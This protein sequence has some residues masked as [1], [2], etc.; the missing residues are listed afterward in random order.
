[1]L[2]TSSV[3]SFGRRRPL[4]VV[5]LDAGMRVVATRTMPP[6]RVVVVPSSRMIVELPAGR[7]LPEIGDRVEITN[8]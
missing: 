7:P 5:G 2:R 4:E 6:N 8:G 1:M 3:H